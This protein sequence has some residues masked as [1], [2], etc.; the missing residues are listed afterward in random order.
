MPMAPPEPTKGV[1]RIP[2]PPAGS[3]PVGQTPH[4]ETLYER[5]IEEDVR[6]ANGN[7]V[8]DPV[9]GPDGKEVWIKHPT[10]GA[11]IRKRMVNRRQKRTQ[12]FFIHVHRNSRGV[13]TG[14]HEIVEYTDLMEQEMLQASRRKDSAA[15]MEEVFARA[16]ARGMSPDEVLDRL[17]APEKAERAPQPTSQHKPD[18]D[19]KYPRWSG[20]V[21]GWQLSNQ[22]YVERLDGE[23]KEPYKAR[24]IEAENALHNKD[25]T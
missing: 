13:A 18:P 22:A 10:T 5:E 9:V 12:R 4:G 7:I 16:Q 23:E 17:D 21:T 3:R 11:F 2:K 25:G 1:L 6:D 20:P 19:A 24:A 15:F 8:R 14:T